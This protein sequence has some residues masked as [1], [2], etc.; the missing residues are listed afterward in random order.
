VTPVAIVKHFY[1]IDDI[2][3]GFLSGLVI[4]KIDPF[5]WSQD[6]EDDGNGRL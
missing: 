5:S 1:V 6:D 4:T 2:S 3:P